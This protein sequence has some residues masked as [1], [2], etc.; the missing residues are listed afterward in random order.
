MSRHTR[1]IKYLSNRQAAKKHEENM[2]FSFPLGVLAGAL[3][4]VLAVRQELMSL[5]AS[6]RR[7]VLTVRCWP[8]LV[9][10]V[11]HGEHVVGR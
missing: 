4:A 10:A 1:S 2:G 7:F 8:H 5:A 6:E 3:W 11:L 9:L